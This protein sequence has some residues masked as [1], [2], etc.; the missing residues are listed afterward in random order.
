MQKVIDIWNWIQANKAAIGGALVG[1][2]AFLEVVV[3]LTPTKKD[4]T[5]LERVGQYV[6]KLMDLVGIPNKKEGGGV[7][8]P[9]NLDTGK[10]DASLK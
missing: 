6:G 10:P 1:L 2:Y 9:I 5:V 3:R 7:H 4:D 8:D